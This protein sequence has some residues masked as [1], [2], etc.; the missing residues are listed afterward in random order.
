MKTAL[1]TAALIFTA[2]VGDKTQLFVAA[3]AGKFSLGTV[4]SGVVAGIAAVHALAVA[5]GELLTGIVPMNWVQLASGG[6]F[7]GFAI[8]SLRA[9]ESEENARI[10]PTVS[11]FFAIASSFFV[12]E[13]GDKTQLAAVALSARYGQPFQVW[14]GALVGMT[15]ADCLGLA[16]G[17]LLSRKASADTV[18]LASSAVFTM[19]A[20]Y[21]TWM[22]VAEMPLRV[23][24]A[25]LCAVIY[26]TALF[27]HRRTASSRAD[28]HTTGR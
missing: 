27:A 28:S 16:A 14:A 9:D 20:V 5:A 1:T 7:L 12:A 15:V 11:P 8:W 23:G 26:L 10:R 3:L 18:R 4:L 17:Y 13:L 22:A 24:L 6:A 25:V 21:N 2:E 19:F